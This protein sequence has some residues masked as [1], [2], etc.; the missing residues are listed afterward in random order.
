MGPSVPRRRSTA[1]ISAAFLNRLATYLGDKDAKKFTPESYDVFTDV[2]ADSD[3]AREIMWL[4]SE[5]ISTGYK[6]KTFRGMTPGFRQD[7]AA[8]LHRLQL[9]VDK[10]LNES[11]HATKISMTSR[12]AYSLTVPVEGVSYEDLEKAVDGGKVEWHSHSREGYT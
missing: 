12:N 1:R 9:N 11:P 6:D 4:S 2:N 5:A 3:H 8:F 10:M 7:M